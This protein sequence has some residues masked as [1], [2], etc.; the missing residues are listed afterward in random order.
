MISWCIAVCSVIL[1]K[2]A[3]AGVWHKAGDYCSSGNSLFAEDTCL[4]CKCWSLW[5]KQWTHWFQKRSECQGLLR[6]FHIAYLICLMS[7]LFWAFHI[8]SG[9][10]KANSQLESDLGTNAFNC[11][12]ARKV[13]LPNPNDKGNHLTFGIMNTCVCNPLTRG[14]V[15][16]QVPEREGEGTAVGNALK[17]IL[18]SPGCGS[19]ARCVCLLAL[20]YAFRKNTTL[21]N[22]MKNIYPR[23]WEMNTEK[24]VVLWHTLLAGLYLL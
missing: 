2:G 6:G 8:R 7:C 23:A 11:S 16:H 18:R 24:N 12:W 21:H 9:E 17:I 20:T 22:R 4:F 15:V 13:Y 10:T 5:V 19:R 1:W 3:C 14:T